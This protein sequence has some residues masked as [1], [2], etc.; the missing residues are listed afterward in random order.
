MVDLAG[1]DVGGLSLNAEH[2]LGVLLVGDAHVYI[3]AQVGHG[4]PGLL[5][6]PQLAAVVQVAGDLDPVGLG[7]LTGLPADV[8]HI[9]TQGRS[10]AGE[11]EPVDPVKDFVP[12]EVGGGGLL[13]GGVSPVVD[14]HGAALRGALLIEVDAHT[15]AAPD[16]H[17]G[18]HAVAAQGVHRRLADGVGG[19]LGDV[20]GVQAVVGQGDGYIGLTAAEGELQVI[21]LDEAL[22]VVGLEPD[23][24]LAEGNDFCH[25]LIPPE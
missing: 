5:A 1:V 21:G 8:H 14:A 13:N 11:V 4:L 23:H 17:G 16:D 7:G 19:Q 24:Q 20:G 6:G 15:V 22:V 9:G 10:D 12:V 2:V 18:V 25:D 3:L